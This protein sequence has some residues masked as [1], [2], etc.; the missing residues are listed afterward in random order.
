VF[1][2]VLLVGLVPAAY[3]DPPDP[4]WIGGFW[5]DD[6]F[7]TVVAFIASTFATFA[8]SDVDAKPCL[9]WVDRAEPPSPVFVRPPLRNASR[10]R[11]PPIA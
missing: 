11:A 1:L 3:A 9:V 5:D 10:P 2:L 7:D 8:Q 4:S 6:D